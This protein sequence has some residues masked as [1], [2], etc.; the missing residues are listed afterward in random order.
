MRGT[1]TDQAS[2]LVDD[3]QKQLQSLNVYAGSELK[4]TISLINTATPELPWK[5]YNFSAPFSTQ[6]SFQANGPG[7]YR[8]SLE[9]DTS[10]A[11]TQGSLEYMMNV[12]VRR[13]E[14][15]YNII[16][17]DDLDDQVVDTILFY[18]GED[19]EGLE[20]ELLEETNGPDTLLFS[21]ELFW[22]DVEVEVLSFDGLTE[23]PDQMT[24]RMKFT[25]SGGAYHEFEV[26]LAEDEAD[27]ES[28]H[29][30]ATVW[31]PI[32]GFALGGCISL[33]LPE[34]FDPQELDSVT[35]YMGDRD[36]EPD[37]FPLAEN[38]SV[39]LEFNGNASWADVTVSLVDFQPL[40]SAIDTIPPVVRLSRSREQVVR[41][42][43]ASSVRGD[44]SGWLEFDLPAGL[45]IKPEQ[46][47][48]GPIPKGDKIEIPVTFT[49]TT[50]CPEGRR[51]LPVRVHYWRANGK[52][53]TTTQYVATRAMIGITVEPD[54]RQPGNT[55]LAINTPFYSADADMFNGCIMRLSDPDGRAVLDGSPL[56]TI[57]D[58]NGKPVASPET[59]A[60]NVWFAGRSMTPLCSSHYIVLFEEDRMIVPRWRSRQQIRLKEAQ[61][62]VPGAW[63][64]PGGAPQWKRIIA[65]DDQGR[66][67]DAGPG[68][69]A[70]IAA[71]ELEFPQSPWSLAFQFMPPRKVSIDGT[72]MEFTIVP[73]D[74]MMSIGFCP[75]GGLD[76]WRKK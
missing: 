64:S 58:E 33:V 30:I 28:G 71:A 54:D 12:D 1:V 21:G 62:T 53:D 44:A 52:T 50:D 8:V 45:A 56:F 60:E 27:P 24:V 39:A 75:V 17:G 10:V 70:P 63:T 16:V 42:S 37:D 14:H 5:P 9:T 61:F 29:F 47:A 15:K 41:V 55:H 43:V 68:Q 20:N 32:D 18:A 35:C 57:A 19:R 31:E 48:F 3:P 73:L 38:P 65:V 49:A 13:V 74:E 69:E 36:P 46:P 34:A 2:D 66:E 6:F 51:I 11:G 76:G 23:D 22:A 4:D 40:T 72:K 7:E 67:F 59:F 26:T 25:Y